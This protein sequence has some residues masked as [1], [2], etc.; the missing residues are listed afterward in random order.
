MRAN[1]LLVFFIAVVLSLSAVA[2]E[3]IPALPSE[4]GI[5]AEAVAMLESSASADVS[6]DVESVPDEAI[7]ELEEETVISELE[8]HE[9]SAL[10]EDV[11]TLPDQFGYGLK[12]FRENMRVAFASEARKAEI[13]LELARKRL[14]EARALARKGK[15][16]AAEKVKEEHARRLSEAQDALARLASGNG[17]SQLKAAVAFELKVRR[18][19]AA[20][21][22]VDS[23]L[24]L[25][26]SGNLSAE[27]R[28]KLDALLGSFEQEG[29]K[30]RLKVKE[31]KEK[32]RE[33]ANASGVKVDEDELEVEAEAEQRGVTGQGRVAEEF[34]RIAEN[35]ISEAKERVSGLENATVAMQRI[36]EAEAKL[37]EARSAF[38]SNDYARA[39]VLAL[40]ARRIVMAPLIRSR[41]KAELRE[42]SMEK[43]KELAGKI[44]EKKEKAV[45]KLRE[46]QKEQREDVREKVQ[47]KREEAKDRIEE[48]KAAVREKVEVRK[49]QAKERVQERRNETLAKVEEKR[50][51][52]SDNRAEIKTEASAGTESGTVR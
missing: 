28:Q 31:R 37:S 30:L 33:L 13:R 16:E 19:I 29:S 36:A 39:R 43:R 20:V 8:E 42:S 14:L 7:A 45:E 12:K 40:E 22:A 47:E 23:D 32:A 41:L 18:H 49:E 24:K 38:Q 2:D 15:L 25:R 10:D 5:S 46:R 51:E 26:L 17:T 52:I 27:Q 3:P 1:V 6:V 21:R 50:L 48:R 9:S 34:I 35:K 11:G 44:M 4:E